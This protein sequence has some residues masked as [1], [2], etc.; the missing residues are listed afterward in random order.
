MLASLNGKFTPDFVVDL[1]QNEVFVF[2]SNLNGMHA[3][4]A[5]LMA[6]KNF[7]AEWGQAEGPQGQCYAIPTDIRGEAVGNVS[8]YMKKHI[9]KFI[10]YIRF[11]GNRSV[12][13]IH[14]IILPVVILKMLHA[15]NIQIYI[16]V[17]SEHKYIS[18]FYGISAYKHPIL[19]IQYRN[20]ARSMSRNIYD[21]KCPAT[22]VNQITFLYRNN[23]SLATVMSV[24]ILFCRAH[25]KFFKSTI[26]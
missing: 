17:R 15:L 19:F 22:Q 2:G 9:D 8:N 23:L 18:I 1:D 10:D 7:G 24:I 11:H 5:S 3:G 21:T 12:H 25:I 16:P 20:A 4:G 26:S 6:L 14:I 13:G